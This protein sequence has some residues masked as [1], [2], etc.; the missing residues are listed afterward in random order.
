M[1]GNWL[2]LGLWRASLRR[3]L[4][5][6]VEV[7]YRRKCAMRRKASGACWLV[8]SF[9]LGGSLVRLGALPYIHSSGYYES[10]LCARP[11]F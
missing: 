6:S 4:E 3:R 10:P 9:S 2:D 1:R 8:V 11:C 7:G 5:L